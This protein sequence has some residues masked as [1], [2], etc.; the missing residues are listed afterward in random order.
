MAKTKKI[1]VIV[2]VLGALLGGLAFLLKKQG[3]AVTD[4][5][6]DGKLNVVTTTTMVTDMVK[7]VG[8]DRISVQSLMGP[9]VDPHS[10]QVTFKDTAALKKA[11]LQGVCH[12]G[13]D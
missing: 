8:G 1:V 11:D 13:L 4:G 3:D 7:A 12:Y 6:P 10:Y 2:L 5:S 9:K